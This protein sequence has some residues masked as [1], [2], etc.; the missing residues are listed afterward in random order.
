MSV[1]KSTQIMIAFQV[2]GDRESD[3]VSLLQTITQIALLIWGFWQQANRVRREVI[4][5]LD[6][7]QEAAT[8]TVKVMAIGLIALAFGV[9][10][11]L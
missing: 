9:G 5:T 11:R 1:M 10:V 7:C 8:F 6:D 4:A 3:L 2:E